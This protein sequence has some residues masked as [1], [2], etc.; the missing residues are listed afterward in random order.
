MAV[1]ALW[2][3]VRR[4]AVARAANMPL[5]AA[6]RQPGNAALLAVGTQAAGALAGQLVAL[7]GIALAATGA[8]PRAD[9]AASIAIG[10]VLAAVAAVM[11]IEVKRVL[12]L[13]G[14]EAIRQGV[15]PAVVPLPLPIASVP[16]EAPLETKS[17]PQGQSPP[18]PPA[19]KPPIKG[20]KGRG[21]HRR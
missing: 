13:P 14:G 3:V 5:L 11:A 1:G 8:H 12:G 10:L 18:P 16:G 15:R 19:H 6:L 9:A 7:A 17:M 2:A 4:L 20:K 21:K